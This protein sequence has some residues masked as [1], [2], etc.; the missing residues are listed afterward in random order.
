M[1]QQWRD[2]RENYGRMM[3]GELEVI[4]ESAYELTDIA[5]EA[6]Q[7]AIT[8]RGLNVALK[9][10]RPDVPSVLPDAPEPPDD[11]ELM[12][13]G[14]MMDPEELKKFKEELAA[15]GTA[16]YI[17][18]DKVMEPEDYKGSF[19]G[20]VQVKIRRVDWEHTM[21][22][23]MQLRKER[24]GEEQEESEEQEQYAV[25]CP[26]CRSAEVVLEG[27]DSEAPDPPPGAKFNWSCDDCGHQWQDDGI[28][29]PI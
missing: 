7:S 17:G 25:L 1:E 12:P 15:V 19:E 20:G 13:F 2:L 3:D 6:L 16:C 9:T 14:W 22:A 4:A 5:R 21:P 27:R 29:Q 11:D 24:N 23:L 28:E 26:K 18:P 8:E 10:T